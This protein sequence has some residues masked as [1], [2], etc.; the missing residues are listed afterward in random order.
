[1]CKRAM[2]E[3]WSLFWPVALLTAFMSCAHA[4]DGPSVIEAG[5]RECQKSY[6]HNYDQSPI[7]VLRS[8]DHWIVRFGSASDDQAGALVAVV[9]ART[10]EGLDCSIHPLHTKE[11]SESDFRDMD[12]SQSAKALPTAGPQSEHI[13]FGWG[14]SA[15]EARL[16]EEA[17]E[18]CPN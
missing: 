1:M 2:F 16:A 10:G 5:V 4:A 14:K 12:A 11:L 13:I 7:F 3:G 17:G 9:D 15:P 18:A 6:G 8:G